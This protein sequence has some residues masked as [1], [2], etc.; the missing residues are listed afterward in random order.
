MKTGNVCKNTF[1]CR[2]N[3]CIAYFVLIYVSFYGY[4]EIPNHGHRTF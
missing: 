4:K 3:M 1:S 2:M